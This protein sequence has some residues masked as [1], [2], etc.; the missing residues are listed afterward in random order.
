MGVQAQYVVHKYKATR[1]IKMGIFAIFFFG[2]PLA[3]IHLFETAQ[4]FCFRYPFHSRI[5]ISGLIIAPVVSEKACRELLSQTVAH[6]A[7]DLPMMVEM[8]A[9]DCAIVGILSVT[10]KDVKIRPVAFYSH[11]LQ[12]TKQTYHMLDK[13]LLAIFEV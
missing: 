10:T 5:L 12:T 2:Q 1:S 13:A 11:T 3:T 4:E 6:C 9:S 7:P 8:D